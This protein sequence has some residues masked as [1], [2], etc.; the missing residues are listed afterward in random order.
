MQVENGPQPGECDPCNR[1]NQFKLPKVFC[2]QARRKDALRIFCAVASSKP[3]ETHCCACQSCGFAMSTS[4]FHCHSI[5]LL[6]FGKTPINRNGLI[7]GKGSL[8]KAA[9]TSS[10][11]SAEP[12]TD[13]T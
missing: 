12:L 2:L 6:P 1:R 3:E 13:T 4:R 10:G 11:V 5:I 9:W 7:C 8:V